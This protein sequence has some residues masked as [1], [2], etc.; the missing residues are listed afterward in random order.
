[1]KEFE[2]IIDTEEIANHFFIKLIEKG[3]S[4]TEEELDVLADIVF[5]YLE[6]K[7]IIEEDSEGLE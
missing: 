1:M 6:D 3:Y 5:D 7:G 2:V 4:P